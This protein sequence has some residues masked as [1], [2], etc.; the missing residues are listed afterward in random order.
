MPELL[1][2]CNLAAALLMTGLIWFVQIVHYPLMRY[3]E[4]DSSLYRRYQERHMSRTTWVVIAPM[5][6]ELFSSFGLIFWRPTY[7]SLTAAL[8]SATLVV[9]IWCS[10]FLLQVPQHQTLLKGFSD[11]N[12]RRLVKGNWIR[13]ISWSAR[14]ILLLTIASG[15]MNV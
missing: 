7:V 13:T 4:H 5:F 8:V 14:S 1:L 9:L 10:T 15:H 3:V 12:H 11:L 6:V 2:L